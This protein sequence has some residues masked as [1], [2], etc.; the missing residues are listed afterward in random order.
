MWVMIRA[1]RGRLCSRPP[2]GVVGFMDFEIN[3]LL[4]YSNKVSIYAA[5]DVL[6]LTYEDMRR[7]T[8]NMWRVTRV[9][10]G[11]RPTMTNASPKD[12]HLENEPKHSIPPCGT[13]HSMSTRFHR[14]LP[15]S[16]GFNRFQP[17]STC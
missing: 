14:F 3:F 7:V 9:G 16:T 13:Q 4:T 6:K 2:W 10:A 5:R 17:V 1:R 8:C 15:N 11:G 12:T